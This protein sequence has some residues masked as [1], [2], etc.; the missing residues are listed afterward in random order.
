MRL[1]HYENSVYCAV[2]LIFEI[3]QDSFSNSTMYVSNIT[4]SKKKF[5][6]AEKFI[7][8]KV[9]ISITTQLLKSS[10]NIEIVL[11]SRFNT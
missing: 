9:G 4:I 2:L 6:G 7:I 1:F 11:I 8:A 3:I 10:A 5:C